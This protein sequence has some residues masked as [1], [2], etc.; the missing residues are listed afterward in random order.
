MVY[1]QEV[2]LCPPQPGRLGQPDL[3]LMG[4][5]ECSGL[6]PRHFHHHHVLPVPVRHRNMPDLNINLD[7]TL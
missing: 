1:Q 5:G 7:E 3:L 6:L 2:S 4:D